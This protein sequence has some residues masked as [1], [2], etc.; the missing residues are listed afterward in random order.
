MKKCISH[1]FQKLIVF[2]CEEVLQVNQVG[3][4]DDVSKNI[5]PLAPVMF[6]SRLV[7]KLERNLEVLI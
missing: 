6:L 5:K 4:G 3:L 7:S 1:V 2:C